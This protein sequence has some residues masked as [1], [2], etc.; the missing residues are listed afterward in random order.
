LEQKYQCTTTDTDE[1]QIVE[2]V[3]NQNIQLEPWLS[4]LKTIQFPRMPNT[5]GRNMVTTQVVKVMSNL[6]SFIMSSRQHLSDIRSQYRPMVARAWDVHH[7]MQQASQSISS[8]TKPAT[9]VYAEH[10]KTQSGVAITFGI[11]LMLNF[12]LRVDDPLDAKMRA[13]H[14]SFI[15][16]IITE[17]KDGLK[18]FPLGSSWGPMPLTAVLTIGRGDIDDEEVRDLLGKYL[19]DHQ[20]DFWKQTELRVQEV[21]HNIRCKLRPESSF[22]DLDAG[23][24]DASGPKLQ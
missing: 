17:A 18:Y 11:C 1:L 4:R 3:V 8:S 6:R 13:D 20:R 22:K 24:F 5:T 10:V 2:S 12:I 7:Q 15:N 23:N 14:L 16:V 19:L 9:S 21:L